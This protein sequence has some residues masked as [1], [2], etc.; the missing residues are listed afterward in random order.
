MKSVKMSASSFVCKRPW[1]SDETAAE[2]LSRDEE[3]CMATNLF[4]WSRL[5]IPAHTGGLLFISLVMYFMQINPL[6]PTS[7]FQRLS[8]YI[9]RHF[10]FL[11]I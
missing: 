2:V 10:K 9:V 8:C 3:E 11:L 7:S 5:I 4:W 1:E 6:L